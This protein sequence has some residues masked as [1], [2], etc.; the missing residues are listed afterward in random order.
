MFSKNWK[1]LITSEVKMYITVRGMPLRV[2]HNGTS[3]NE[4]D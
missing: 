1:A 2:Q 4:Q 3:K